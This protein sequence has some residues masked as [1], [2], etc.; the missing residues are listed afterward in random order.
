MRDDRTKWPPAGTSAGM[1]QLNGCRLSPVHPK[2]QTLVSGAGLSSRFDGPFLGWPDI[3]DTDTYV[4]SLRRDRI[5]IVN[6][7][8]QQ[9]GWDSARNLAISDFTDGYAVFDLQGPAA[10][11]VLRRGTEITLETPSRSVARLLFGLG[12]LVYR[13]GQED[14]FRLH[15]ARA[16]RDA[17]LRRLQSSAS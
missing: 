4:L 1:L 15:V 10:F 16:H 8:A 6:G 2:R 13:F 3:A 7:P 11:A 9:D 5:L 17:L 14:G 12:V